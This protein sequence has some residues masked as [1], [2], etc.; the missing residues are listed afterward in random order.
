[1]DPRDGSNQLSTEIA[2]RQEG[3][4]YFTG[5]RHIYM[6]RRVDLFA[7]LS[8]TFKCHN[9]E[10]SFIGHVKGLPANIPQ[11]LQRKPLR[12]YVVISSVFLFCDDSEN[13]ADSK[14][15]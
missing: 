6:S 10:V 13:L 15:P 1:M 8:F 12:L 14:S 11:K 5:R 7:I 3:P 9:F 4:G 2:T